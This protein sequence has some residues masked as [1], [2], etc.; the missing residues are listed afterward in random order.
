MNKLIYPS[1]ERRNRLKTGGILYSVLGIIVAGSGTFFSEP[2]II[3]IGLCPLIIGIGVFGFRRLSIIEPSTRSL[4]TINGLYFLTSS[5]KASFNE[6]SYVDVGK[7][8]STG[9]RFSKFDNQTYELSLNI[10]YDIRII[11]KNGDQLLVESTGNHKDALLW[12]QEIA[13][14]ISCE[15]EENSVT[16]KDNE[17]IKSKL[18]FIIGLILKLAVVAVIF[19]VMFRA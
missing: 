19:V 8:V 17:S 18:L 14:V 9:H 3:F 6:V 15:V 5:K 12:A 16:Q 7:R 10:S 2:M 4:E 13:K 1:E 11:L